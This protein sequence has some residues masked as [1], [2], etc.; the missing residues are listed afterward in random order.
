MARLT[1][2]QAREIDRLAMEEL[3]LPGIVLME[4]AARGIAEAVRRALRAPAGPVAIVCGP[5]NNGGDGFAAARHLANGGIE[6]RLHLMVPAARY[7]AGSD[8]AINLAVA[9]AMGLPLRDDLEF[10]DAACL[11]DAIFGTGLE[12]P[13]EGRFAEAVERINAT[14]AMVVAVDTPSGLDA[15]TGEVLG[16]AVRADLTATMVAPKIGFDQAEGPTHTGRVEVVDIGVPPAL[17]ALVAGG[18]S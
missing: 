15:D 7:A 1:R 14:N 8:P 2:S 3:G 13:V 17:V 5:G 18:D 16:V 9:R 12:R 4:N 11:L 10:D 6:V